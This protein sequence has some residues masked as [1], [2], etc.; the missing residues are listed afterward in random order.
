MHYWP[1]RMRASYQTAHREAALHRPG[2]HQPNCPVAAMV[3]NE[4][5][6]HHIS[7]VLFQALNDVGFTVPAQASPTGTAR[8]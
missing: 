5:G 6:A 2:A 1:F 3:G 7:G 4:D 8:R